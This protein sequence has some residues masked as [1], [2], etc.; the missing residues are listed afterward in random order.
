LGRLDGGREK[1]A[2]AVAL[3]GDGEETW[4]GENCLWAR[5]G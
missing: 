2:D 5:L 1:L 3:L 4:G